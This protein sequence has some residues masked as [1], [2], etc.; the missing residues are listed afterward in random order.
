[1]SAF[2]LVI[3]AFQ[4]FSFSAFGLVLSAFTLNPQLSTINHF[5]SATPNGSAGAGGL[6]VVSIVR[7]DTCMLI[8]AWPISACQLF[9]VSAFA[10]LITAPKRPKL[11]VDPFYFYVLGV[12]TEVS[13]TVICV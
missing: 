5:H 12:R 13:D 6:A 7:T 1:M 11:W 3:S 10:L 8:S 9:S 2:D 4:L